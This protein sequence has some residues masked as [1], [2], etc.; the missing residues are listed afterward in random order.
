[1]HGNPVVSVHLLSSIPQRL[2][3]VGKR[4]TPYRIVGGG[5]QYEQAASIRVIL[6]SYLQ[7]II[8]FGSW[9]S[10]FEQ[11]ARA[12]E[13]QEDSIELSVA[14]SYSRGD[15]E[16]EKATAMLFP[17]EIAQRGRVRNHTAALFRRR[18]SV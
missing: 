15:R 12:H 1:M 6:A 3:A 5:H 7:V 8:Q 10:P 11:D 16:F 13:L 2:V 17:S 14:N 9:D 18:V 4:V